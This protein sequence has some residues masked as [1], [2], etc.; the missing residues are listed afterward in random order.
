MNS[1]I[2]I[3]TNAATQL[4]PSAPLNARA[5]NR[6]TSTSGSLRRRCRMTKITPSTTPTAIE[7]ASVAARPCSAARVIPYTPASTATV[8]SSALA[9]SRRMPVVVARAR[10]CPRTD[11]QQERHRRDVGQEHRSPPEVLQQGSAD[12]RPDRRAGG[13]AAD[14]DPDRRRPLPLIGEHRV[15]SASEDGASDAPATPSSARAAI[16]IAGLVENAATSEPAANA[17]PPAEQQSPV[18][19]PIAE[20]AH[21]EQRAGDQEAV[22]VGDPQ[23]LGSSK[24]AAPASTSARRG[25]A[26]TCPSSPAAS[27]APGPPSRSTPDVPLAPRAAALRPPPD[28]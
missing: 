10:Q 12:Q 27:A 15:I 23:Q 2:P 17:A 16:S 22:D 21:R 18:T 4:A 1:S 6:L 24:D 28:L 20:R 26:P 3:A 19:D 5:R 13:E 11:R 8:A 25:T 9:G 7:P 14:P